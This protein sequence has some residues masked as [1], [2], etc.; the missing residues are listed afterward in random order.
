MLALGES[1]S[2]DNPYNPLF[3]GLIAVWGIM[4]CGGYKRL[5]V[6]YQHEWD[7]VNFEPATPDRRDFVQVP[8]KPFS[9]LLPRP[10]LLSL[11]ALRHLELSFVA[12][13]HGLPAGK[14]FCCMR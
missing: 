1:G 3:A 9:A 11:C 14:S 4:F 2:G 6:V 13:C 12:L 8:S 5:Q 7:T 10:R